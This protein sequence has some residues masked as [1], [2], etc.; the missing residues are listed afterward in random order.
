VATPN[1]L[2]FPFTGPKIDWTLN[3]DVTAEYKKIIAFRNSSQAIRRG[4]VTSYSSADVCVFTK[5]IGTEKVVVFSN[6]RNGP[7]TYNLPPVLTTTTWTDAMN[8]TALTL[9]T[10]L[11]LQP[12][13][14]I[15]LKN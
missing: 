3:P 14:Y 12:Y 13:A 1:R 10:Q 9:D 6:L 15:I 7:V 2:T 8:G 4:Q 5:E 11:S